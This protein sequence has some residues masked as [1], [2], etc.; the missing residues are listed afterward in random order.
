M[1]DIVIYQIGY[2][3]DRLQVEEIKK[4]DRFGHITS[5]D[6]D[7]LAHAKQASE[8][9]FII[10]DNKSFVH[11]KHVYARVPYSINSNA[12]IIA[13]TDDQHR[14]LRTSR[15]YNKTSYE[16]KAEVKFELKHSYFGRLH[17]VLN[18]LPWQVITRLTPIRKA[19]SSASSNSSYKIDPYVEYPNIEL[20]EMQMKALNN[21][22]KSSPRLP[23]LV[24]G[25]F[26]TGKTRL[27]ARAAY[28]ILENS[29]TSRVMICAHHQVSANTFLE[30][31]GSMILDEDIPW[32][33]EMV[34][35]VPNSSY[36]KRKDKYSRF[37][38]TKFELRGN[39]Q[40][41]R[42][43]ITTLGVGAHILSALPGDTPEEK[44]QFFTD[45]LIDEGAQ[46]REPETVGPLCV[47]GVNTRII[48]AGDH[49]QVGIVVYPR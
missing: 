29:S 48:I 45:I 39:L 49:C 47:A 12:I 13:F 27:L 19:F 30:H 42:L 6:G 36:Q 8:G 17:T 4:F 34:R 43:V 26:G 10:L 33:V 9:S 38:K 14:K 40:K 41:S 15:L 31:F 32:D 16:F 5:D 22:L 20:D 1:C 3:P 37:V 2:I 35:V 25:P 21:I 11:V 7:S 46:T 44:R 23:V 28:E 18:N 24:A